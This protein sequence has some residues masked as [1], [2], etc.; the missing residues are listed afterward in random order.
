MTRDVGKGLVLLEGSFPVD[1]LNPGLK[2]LVHYGPQTGTRGLLEWFA[3]WCFERNNKRVK[4]MVK[5]T[6]Q[7][8]SSLAN[9][10]E[11]DIRTKM[12]AF[13][14][15]SL[16]QKAEIQL[17][18]KVKDYDLSDRAAETLESLGVTSFRDLTFFKVCKLVGVHFRSGE[19]GC[20]RS[21]SVITTIYGGISRYCIVDM[22]LRVQHTAY[23]CVT[24]LSPPIY[25]C[26]P[27][28]LVVKVRLMAPA[29]QRLHR[30]VIPVD[31]IDP[32][33]VAVLPDNDGIHF[34]MMRDKGT[35][36][37]QWR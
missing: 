11:L 19:W 3:M 17:T 30:G 10:V 8:L 36:R 33:T 6:V 15:V 35:D 31:K 26:R 25:P 7:A 5:H 29:E 24:W 21:G 37:V 28:T 34:Y 13:S 32:C 22:F 2:H 20:R 1:H 14:K 18:V 16:H 27:F 4:S 12:D 23:A 9:H